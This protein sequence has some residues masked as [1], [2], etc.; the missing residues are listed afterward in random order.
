MLKTPAPPWIDWRPTMKDS[1]AFPQQ[2]VDFGNGPDNPT[3]YGMGGLTIQQYAAI[4][5]LQPTSGLDWLDDMIRARMRDEIAG[6]VIQGAYSN[7]TWNETPIPSTSKAA[8]IQADSM[9]KQREER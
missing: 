3:G 6:R 1:P 4:H 9:M 5:L 7:S 2:P 8:Y